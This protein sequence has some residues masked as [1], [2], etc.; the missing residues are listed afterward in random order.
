MGDGWAAFGHY[1]GRSSMNAQEYE[2]GLAQIE[3]ELGFRV[4]ETG[5]HHNPCQ[6]EVVFQ[7]PYRKKGGK[8][9]TR[10]NRSPTDPQHLRLWKALLHSRGLLEA[11]ELK[12]GDGRIVSMVYRKVD[13]QEPEGLKCN[14]DELG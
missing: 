10:G 12:D 5:M 4:I 3:A 11:E 1:E 9:E 14:P 2:E 13:L 7:P 6:I 8:P